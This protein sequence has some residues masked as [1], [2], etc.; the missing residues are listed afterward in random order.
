M[1]SEFPNKFISNIRVLAKKQL[2]FF[3]KEDLLSTQKGQK[4]CKKFRFALASEISPALFVFFSFQFEEKRF[5]TILCTTSSF[6]DPMRQ[7][8]AFSGNRLQDCIFFI[9]G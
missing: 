8:F 7:H 4:F 6:T 9:R 3:L 1:Y 2:F 5:P